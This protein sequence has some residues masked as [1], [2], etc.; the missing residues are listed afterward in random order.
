MEKETGEI[1]SFSSYTWDLAGIWGH[2]ILC[3]MLG[4]AQGNKFIIALAS[5]AQILEEETDIRRYLGQCLNVV[6]A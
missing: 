2:C 4:T 3:L 5:A 1:L 6:R